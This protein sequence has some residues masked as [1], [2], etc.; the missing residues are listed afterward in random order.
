MV[1]VLLGDFRF[2]IRGAG[3]PGVREA[4]G[5]HG[6]ATAKQ[7]AGFPHWLAAGQDHD[8][9]PA[10]ALAAVGPGAHDVTKLRGGKRL[11]SVA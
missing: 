1:F 4:E 6:L 9:G 10:A 5:A 7:D 11:A 8:G 2:Q 3:D